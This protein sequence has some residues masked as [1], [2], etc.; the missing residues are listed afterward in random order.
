MDFA[1]AEAAGGDNGPGV[2]FLQLRF[3]DRGDLGRG[4]WAF[5][6]IIL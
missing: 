6:V 5:A 2:P 1:A 3:E 4:G